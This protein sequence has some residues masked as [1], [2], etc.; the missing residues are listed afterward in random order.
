MG[1][2][3]ACRRFSYWRL[4]EFHCHIFFCQKVVEVDDGLA[5]PLRQ[6]GTSQFVEVV[7]QVLCFSSLEPAAQNPI[8]RFKHIQTFTFSPGLLGMAWLV[9]GFLGSLCHG[10]VATAD[11]SAAR[12]GSDDKDMLSR[13]NLATGTAMLQFPCAWPDQHLLPGWLE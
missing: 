4:G 5:R 9:P 12:W 10:M 13:W 1:F 6:H 3:V 2:F 7:P 11:C 8:Y